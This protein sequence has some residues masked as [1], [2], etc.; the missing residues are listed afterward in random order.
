MKPF[1][2]LLIRVLGLYLFLSILFSVIPVFFGPNTREFWSD[3]L[4]PVLLATVVV[5]MVGSVLLW[6]FADR[7]ASRLHGDVEA[8]IRVKDDDLV[9]AGT[10]LIGV[11][12]VVRHIGLL[13]GEYTSFGTVA[14]GALVVV[15]AGLCMMLGGRFLVALYRKVKYFGV[16]EKGS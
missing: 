16:E 14:Y 2:I 5:P 4:L 7:L 15:I 9:R 6:C 3:E 8:N 13:V 1:S 11:Y 10:F 12:L